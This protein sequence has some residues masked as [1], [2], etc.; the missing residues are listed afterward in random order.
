MLEC[1]LETALFLNLDNELFCYGEQI[2]VRRVN[3]YLTTSGL[4]FCLFLSYSRAEDLDGDGRQNQ[5]CQRKEVAEDA[6][7]EDG[8]P[9]LGRQVPDNHEQEREEWAERVPHEAEMEARL[10]DAAERH[11]ADKV[12]VDHRGHGVNDVGE[13]LGE[14]QVVDE[15]QP[16]H[17]LI[18]R[19]EDLE[20]GLVLLHETGD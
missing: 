8:V 20:R 18:V 10:R 3:E 4:Y 6:V 17:D 1:Q 14:A 2:L 5:E 12:E 11:E 9:F 16:T 13:G 7:G 15:A 19:E